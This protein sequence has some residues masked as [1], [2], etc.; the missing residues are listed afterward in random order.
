MI[1]DDNMTN[2]KVLMGQLSL[3]GMDAVCASSADEALSLMRHAAAAGRPFEVALLD[4]Q[5]PGCDGATLGKTILAEPAAAQ[6]TPDPAD[7][8]RA[9]RRWAHV[10]GAGFCGLSVEA[11]DPSRSH[12]LPA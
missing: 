3:C 11:G 6:R 1:V 7:L 4:H 12:R 9:A 5:M 2:R 10:L 8:L